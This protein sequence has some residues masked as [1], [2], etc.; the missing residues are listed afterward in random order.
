ME[1]RQI[2][3]VLPNINVNIMAVD[4]V[5]CG[6]DPKG[7]GDD[8]YKIPPN[9]VNYGPAVFCSPGITALATIIRSKGNRLRYV[10]FYGGSIASVLPV[11]LFLS[12]TYF[13]G[14]PR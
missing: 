12:I 2:F 8:T 14:M 1:K 10:D 3:V 11:A 4:P 7:I 6:N 13:R 5:P 9:L